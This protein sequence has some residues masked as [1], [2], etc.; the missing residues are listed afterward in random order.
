[1]QE[2][3]PETNISYLLKK[4]SENRHPKRFDRESDPEESEWRSSPEYMDEE[5]D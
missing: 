1:M 4:V 3:V 2:V 5:D